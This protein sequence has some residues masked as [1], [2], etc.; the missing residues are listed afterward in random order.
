MTEQPASDTSESKSRRTT[1]LIVF[2]V[3]FIDLL[4]FGIV[5]P[6]LP[7]YGPV[8]YTHLTLPTIYYE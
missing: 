6:L 7:R 3:V 5:L 4:G 8:S 2:V 1:L